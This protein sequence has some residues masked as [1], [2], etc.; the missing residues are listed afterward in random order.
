MS[1]TK[2]DLTIIGFSKTSY[3]QIRIYKIDK[4]LEEL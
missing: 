4:F 3:Q 2:D 1:T